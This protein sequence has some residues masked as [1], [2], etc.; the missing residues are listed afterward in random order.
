MKA[1]MCVI[2]SLRL[3][4]LVPV[5]ALAARIENQISIWF[6]QSLSSRRRGTLL[7]A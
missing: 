1:L 4:K 6:S 3:L 2:N 5:S 7:S